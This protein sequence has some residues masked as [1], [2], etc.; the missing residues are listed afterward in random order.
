MFRKKKSK[1]ATCDIPRDL[2]VLGY[3]INEKN[4][5][6][7]IEDGE[8][9]K[10]E[11]KD[12]AYNERLYDIIME[13]LASWVVEKLQKE[14]GFIK[15]ILPLG[16]TENDIHT[17]IFLTPD[18]ETND[19]MI[20]FIPGTAH[21]AGIWSRRALI[22][23]SVIDGSMINY[24]KRAIDLG[25]SVVLL[26]P[27][28]VFWYKGKGV[29]ILPKTTAPFDT[30][31]GSESPEAHTNYVFENIVMPSAAQRIFIIAN[32][33]GGHC[34]IDVMQNHFNE[35]SERV[36]AIEFTV[37]AHSIDFVKTDRMKVWIREHCRNWLMSDLPIGE[38]II[39]TRF[40]CHS[41]S[42]GSELIE[43]ITYAVIELVFKFIENKLINP[44]NFQ[45]DTCDTDE[46]ILISES[47]HILDTLVNN[48]KRYKFEDDDNCRIVEETEGSAWLS[49]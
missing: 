46:D 29:L 33:Y 37:S 22:D 31:P 41:F 28:E 2:E 5:L 26:N 14:L 32:S 47:Q 11:V 6:V 7:S 10:F 27:N 16:A 21:S 44:E 13:L 23:I 34:A 1:K 39:D 25:F 45:D 9:Y 12:R 24:A 4:Q 42:S 40:G 20:I 43:Y 8:I 49:N 3:K 36:K 18:Y 38:E 35:L 19:K 48:V 17:K 15:K 30:I